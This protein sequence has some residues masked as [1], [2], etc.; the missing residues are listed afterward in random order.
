MNKFWFVIE[1]GEKW[2]SPLKWKG[3]IL[4]LN[5]FASSEEQAQKQK[6]RD[7]EIKKECLKRSLQRT[8]ELGFADQ[9][10]D[11][12]RFAYVY[13]R[14]NPL[15]YKKLKDEWWMQRQNYDHKQNPF[16]YTIYWNPLFDQ[17]K[18][19]QKDTGRKGFPFL[20]KDK[21][22]D[23]RSKYR[24]NGE[25]PANLI[26]EQHR[27]TF[28]R[29]SHQYNMGLLIVTGWAWDR[30]LTF[31]DETVEV[32]SFEELEEIAIEQEELKLWEL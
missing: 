27:L 30:L 17:A 2:P 3:E 14:I 18:P 21:K 20:H 26:I 12:F 6:V 11:E 13:E 16:W 22:S 28:K 29:D 10:I 4:H 31:Y 25:G 19:A 9:D 32:N 5:P 7:A 15:L 8:F 23:P 24:L 1:T